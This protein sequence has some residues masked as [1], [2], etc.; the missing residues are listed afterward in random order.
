MYHY[1]LI[2]SSA[3]GRL[4][5]FQ[6]L[7]IV[8][9]A[10]MNIGVHVSFSIWISSGYMPRIRIVGSYGGFIPGFLRNLYIIF[11]SGCINLHT[12]QQCKSGPFSPHP[13]Q[14]LLFVDFLMMDILTDG[15]SYLTVVLICISLIIGDV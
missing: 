6:V 5:C 1:F 2:H 11:H 10:A 15:R 9:I 12:H 14:Q 3:D 7:A 4:G 13:L 8:N